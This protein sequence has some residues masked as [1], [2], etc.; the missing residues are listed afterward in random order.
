MNSVYLSIGSNIDPA[1]NFQRCAVFIRKH[2]NHAQ[3]SP[4]Y[5]SRAI[6][7]DGPDF[8]NAAVLIKTTLGIDTFPALL[9]TLEKELGRTDEQAAFSNRTIDAD[10][11]L[12]NDS[13]IDLPELTIPRPELVSMA[14][15]LVP[16]VDIAANVIHPRAQK[17]LATLL[18]ELAVLDPGQIEG[19]KKVDLAIEN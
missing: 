7:M 2:F 12:F 17:S 19:L 10:I 1:T 14:F 8:L 16:M 3:W 4:I 5:Q 9:K 13:C 11:V 18:D 6:G 15:V